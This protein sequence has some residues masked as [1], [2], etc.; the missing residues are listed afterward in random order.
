MWTVKLTGNADNQRQ[1]LK[2]WGTQ[3]FGTE[4]PYQRKY[5]YKREALELYRALL[6]K[7]INCDMSRAK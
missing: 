1:A 2:I 3:F 5:A 4:Q 6:L 7:G